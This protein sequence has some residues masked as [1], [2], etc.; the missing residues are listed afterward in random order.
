MANGLDIRR[1]PE[2]NFMYNARKA[3]A[4]AQE[5]ADIQDQ[6]LAAQEGR[7]KQAGAESLWG[8]IGGTI[9]AFFGGPGGAA[10]GAALGSGGADLWYSKWL[11]GEDVEA[12]KIDEP[13][14]NKSKVD[15]LNRQ[16]ELADD[17]GLMKHL[18]TGIKTGAQ[19]WTL[20]EATKLG[21]FGE[22]GIGKFGDKLWG[23]FRR[24]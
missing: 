16:F 18:G 21:G 14:F 15:K 17:A 6:L 8:T 4:K 24:N 9:G 23:S 20:G 1:I 10:I 22:E 11:P 19:A 5:K 13:L 2:G 12:L 7:S 3:V